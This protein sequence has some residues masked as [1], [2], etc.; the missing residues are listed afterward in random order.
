MAKGFYSV[1]KHVL[2]P[3]SLTNLLK[4]ICESAYLGKSPLGEEFVNTLGYSLIFRRSSLGEVVANF[5][6][7]EPYLIAVM[8]EGTNAFYVN[9]LIL[10]GTSKVNA[11]IDCR[12]LSPQNIRIIPN[13]VSVFYAEV[14]REMAGGKL[15]L[16][17]GKDE[18]VTLTP[19]TNSVIHFL[20]KV[21][22]CVSEVTNPERRI[23]VVCEQYNLDD[24]VLEAFPCCQI[25]TG[26][27]FAPR[28]SI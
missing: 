18:E 15:I 22:H 2:D 11:H 28:V 12:L 13:L 27:D 1:Q 23:S 6:Y 24:D 26:Q 17:I 7:L 5:P 9:T 20:G 10:N 21:I 16:N 19:E 14:S 25:I 3:C 4:G 8:F